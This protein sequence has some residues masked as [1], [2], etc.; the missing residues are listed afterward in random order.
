MKFILATHNNNKIKEFKELFANRDIEIISLTDLDYFDDIPETGDTFQE[1]AVQKA[2]T[3]Y[4]LFKIPT[5]ADDSG[6]SVFALDGFPGVQSARF[7]EGKPPTVKNLS[8]IEK[9]EPYSDKRAKFVAAIAVVGI[10]EYPL[11]FTGESHGL[12]INEERGNDGFG[13]DPIFYVPNLL[14]TFAEL[15]SEEKN[16]ISHRGLATSKLLQ[17]IDDYLKE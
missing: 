6:L 10:D 7:M 3:I 9:L 11:V 17:Y 12:I 13:Y 4:D 16:A 5:I 1:N 15:S 8:L 14:K 2:R